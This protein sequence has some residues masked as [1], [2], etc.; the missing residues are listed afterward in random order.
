MLCCWHEL[1]KSAPVTVKMQS[2]RG[3]ICAIQEVRS[4]LQ[5]VRHAKTQPAQVGGLEVPRK[6]SSCVEMVLIDGLGKF[7]VGTSG[8]FFCLVFIFSGLIF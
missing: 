6:T 4:L 3:A 7:P 5:Y 1:W 8:L 2:L